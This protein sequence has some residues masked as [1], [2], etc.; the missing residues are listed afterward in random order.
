MSEMALRLPNNYVD[1]DGDEMEYIDGGSS[2]L[3]DIAALGGVAITMGA[4]MWTVGH[5]YKIDSVESAGILLACFGGALAG[6]CLITSITKSA[7]NK[8]T[9]WYTGSVKLYSGGDW[10][11]NA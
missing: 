7:T 8:L 6:A 9:L 2:V 5:T 11:H 4:F 1:V 3:V 10:S